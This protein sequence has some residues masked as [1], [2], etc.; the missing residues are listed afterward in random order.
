MDAVADKDNRRIKVGGL[1]PCLVF[2]DDL[3]AIGQVNRL[4]AGWNKRELCLVLNGVDG[5]QRN[6]LKV[7]AVVSRRLKAGKRKLRGNV[8]G[9]ELVSACARPAAF[10]QI[11]RQEAHMCANFFRIDGCRCDARCLRQRPA[12]AGTEGTVGCCVRA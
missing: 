11:E 10:Q 4:A 1:L 3:G 8:L 9:G 2:G 5:Q 7:G 6:A 12:I